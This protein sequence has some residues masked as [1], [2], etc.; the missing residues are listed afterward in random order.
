MN[1][2]LK[3]ITA[4]ESSYNKKYPPYAFKI[5]NVTSNHDTLNLQILGCMQKIKRIKP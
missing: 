3:A 1:K 2:K 5:Y 4:N